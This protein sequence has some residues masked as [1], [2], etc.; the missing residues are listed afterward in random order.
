MIGLGWEVASPT[1]LN[2]TASGREGCC[3][4]CELTCFVAAGFF[5][6]CADC[7]R[8]ILLASTAKNPLTL[9]Q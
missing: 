4:M 1:Q 3:F 5:V 6:T 2:K 7:L 9:T 8:V